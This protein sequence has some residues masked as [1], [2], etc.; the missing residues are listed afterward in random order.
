MYHRVLANILA[1]VVC[2]TFFCS[3]PFALAAEDSQDTSGLTPL[4]TLLGQVDDAAFQLDLLKG[5][6]QGLAGRRS[7]PMPKDWPG[8]YDRLAKSKN[9]ARQGKKKNSASC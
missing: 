8:V 3:A 5:I 6:Q 4:V 7:V 9:A 2:A 1:L